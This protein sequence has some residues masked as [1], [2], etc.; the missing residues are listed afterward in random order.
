MEHTTAPLSPRVEALLIAA[1]GGGSWLLPN[2]LWAEIA[3]LAEEA[4]EGDALA[5]WM[6]VCLQA[7]NVVPAIVLMIARGGRGR[8][9]GG[10]ATDRREWDLERVVP[11]ATVVRGLMAL[12]VAA[13]LAL[14]A[15]HG[16]RVYWLGNPTSLPLL[17]L[18][19]VAGVVACT[20]QA[21]ATVPPVPTRAES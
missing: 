13:A 10:P 11:L 14:A 8:A 20:S 15:L 17:S 9:A 2:A 7:A 1:F 16:T 12:E 21:R 5:T 18:V 3:I 4:P 6:V 19:F